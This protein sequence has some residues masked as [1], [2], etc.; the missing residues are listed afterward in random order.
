MFGVEGIE[1]P[2]RFQSLGAKELFGFEDF[3]FP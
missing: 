3:E 2:P 1:G